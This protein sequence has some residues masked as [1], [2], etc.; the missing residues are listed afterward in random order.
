MN[1]NTGQIYQGV[2]EI[3]AARERGEPVVEVSPRVAKLMTEAL[4]RR[5]RRAKSRRAMQ[6]ASRRVNRRR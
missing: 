5:R 4:D 1:T 6:K 2:Y 3:E